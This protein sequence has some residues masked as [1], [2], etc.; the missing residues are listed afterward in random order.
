MRHVEQ[1]PGS[2][3]KRRLEHWRGIATAQQ[4]LS[5]QIT[6]ARF[7]VFALI[8]LTAWVG[9][10]AEIFSPWWAALPIAAFIALILRHERVIR[11]QQKAERAAAYYDNG[12]A[13]LEDRWQG[14]GQT[15]ERFHDDRHPYAGDLD[16]FGRGSLFE[17][18]C[19][20][21]TRAGEERVAKWL[22]GPAAPAIVLAR[23]Q[24]VGELR[25][26]LDLREDIALLGAEVGVGLEPQALREWSAAPPQL[27]VPWLRIA[28]PACAIAAALSGLAWAAE[29]LG[30]LPF[31]IAVFVV[32]ALGGAV[33]RRVEAVIKGVE[34]AAR[35]LGLL[36]QLLARLE[37]ERFECEALR[38]LRA[39]LDVDGEPPSAQIAA[40]NRRVE[41]LDARRNQLFAP[42]AVL[43]LWGTQ[44]ALAIEAWRARHGHAVRNWLEAV[45]E[46]EALSSLAAHAFEHPADP[47]AEIA[48]EE[49]C[50]EGIGI[51]HPLL[52]EAEC[53]RNDVNLGAGQRVLIVS[54]SNMSGKSTLLR[55]VG[56]N[57]A[58]ALA[59]APVRA[60]RVR[61]SPLALGASLRIVDSLQAG[62]SHFY[63]EIKRLRQL[64]DIAAGKPPLLFLLDEI[65]HG[66]NS[67]D[68]RIGAEAVVRDL[69]RRGAIG[70]V[71]THDLALAQIA[72]RAELHAINVHFEDHLEDGKMSFD[73]KMRSGVVTKSNALALMRSVGLDV[74][75]G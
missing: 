37:R 39:A 62:T 53:V 67:H 2:E 21:R 13:R 60:T 45:A 52:P 44:C 28:A 46:F 70:L 10:D 30:P 71:T 18:L 16:L 12:L 56:T 29:M 73:Y 8:V 25:H 55:S 33:H 19:R 75:G 43:L 36:S 20:A 64:V 63:A 27:H 48:D 31:L 47:F 57:T 32:L 7:V 69:I 40:L 42:I 34:R 14:H 9:F 26:R 22:S 61:L 51:G 3:Y 1:N 11:A 4:A 23:Q 15:G 58:L 38:A 72:D 5:D 66:T 65:L 59:G 35:D 50:F 41:L 54:G 17:L 74:T 24:A 68:R 49:A 6:T